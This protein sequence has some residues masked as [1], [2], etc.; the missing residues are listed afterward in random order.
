MHFQILASGSGGN[1]LYVEC[2]DLKVLIDA[3]LPQRELWQ[4]FEAARIDVSQI[5]H[6]LVTHGHLDHARS[7]GL[8]ARAAG[9]ILHCSPA[10]FHNASIRRHKRLADWSPSRPIDLEPRRG[11]GSLRAEAVLVPHD[12]DPTYAVRLESE[13]RVLCLV[14]DLGEA[15]PQLA[16]RL[17][18]AHALLLEFNHDPDLLAQGPYSAALKR[19]IAGPR[20]HLSNAQAAAFLAQLAGPELERLFLCHLSQHNNTPELALAAAAGVALPTRLTENPP[21]VAAQDRIGARLEV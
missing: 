1:S 17:S 11:R 9:A 4:R 18:G 3:G 16:A 15:P 6:V 12:A 5:D 13:G 2:G 7:A 8:V 10:V 21:E 19:R 20:G 14:T